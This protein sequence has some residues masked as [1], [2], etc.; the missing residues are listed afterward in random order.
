VTAAAEQAE[1][2]RVRVRQDR[3][4]RLRDGTWLDLDH[5]RE[6]HAIAVSLDDLSGIATVT[7]ELVRAGILSAPHL[8]WTV[9]LDDLR[10]ITE[11]AERPAELLLYI[12]RRTEPNVT[13]RFHAVDE[14]DFF[15]EFYA[16]GLYVE[17][18]PDTVRSE[19]PQ[20]GEPS[21]ASKRRFK[22]QGLEFLTSR[23]D[24][25]DAW[26]FH[27]L[28]IRTAP[29]PKPHLGA[30]TELCQ[31]IDAIAARRGPGWLRITTT[32]LDGSGP[33]QRKFAR[34]SRELVELSRHD[35]LFHTLCVAGGSTADNMFVFV[36]ASKGHGQT[37]AEAEE[38]LAYYVSAKKHQLQAAWGAGLLFDSTDP[39]SPLF[40]HYDNR[41][42]RVDPDLDEAVSLLKLRPI[43]RTT[44]SVPR[45]GRRGR[46]T[47][48]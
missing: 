20:L 19:L 6:I 42:L 40:T 11:L 15:L 22:K 38:R 17:P 44:A 9:S 35:G 32:L 1:R 39:M 24:Q 18:D 46:T 8:P 29:A 37:L 28:G 26:Y 10:I 45:P 48:R 12:R 16:S 31:I 30:N 13:R 41:L 23:T 43:E 2:L 25:L 33:L 21:I 27:Q 36:W 7:S 3:G 14:L 47:K 5:V 34:Y 4:L